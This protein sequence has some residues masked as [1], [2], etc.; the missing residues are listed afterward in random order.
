MLKII[1]ELFENFPEII[2]TFNNNNNNKKILY[3][4][5]FEIFRIN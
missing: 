5:K 2:G 3:K 1:S 4:T